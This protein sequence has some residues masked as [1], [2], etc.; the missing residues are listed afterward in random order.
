MAENF[1]IYKWRREML[2]ENTN[3]DDLETIKKL[4]FAQA[5]KSYYGNS[6]PTKKEVEIFADLYFGNPASLNES[7]V[8]IKKIKDITWDDVAGLALPTG[9][10]GVRAKMDNRDI[11]DDKWRMKTLNN[12]KSDLAKHFP[13]A[14]E[15]EIEVDKSAGTSKIIDK[16]YIDAMN[17]KNASAQADYDTLGYK[18]D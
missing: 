4:P 11:F 17:R 8:V 15:F 9:A 2:T 16:E 14:G 18:G 12:W 6:E 5:I 10:S 7:D 3:A 1:N 13:N